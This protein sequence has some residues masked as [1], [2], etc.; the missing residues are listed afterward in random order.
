VGLGTGLGF[1]AVGS[2]DFSPSGALY[3]AVNIAGDGGTGSDHLAIINKTTGAA[4][5]IGPF[6]TCVAS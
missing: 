1:A 4:T 5:V 2:M 3:A 6:G